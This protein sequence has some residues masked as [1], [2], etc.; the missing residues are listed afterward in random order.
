MNVVIETERLLLRRFTIDDAQ[1]V[2]ELNAD[3]EVTYYTHDPIDSVEQAKEVLERS[4]L[5][6]YA[7]YNHGRWAVHLKYDLAFIGWCGLKYRPALNEVDLGYRFKK[8]AWGKG[9]ATEAAWHC[10][11]YG[12]ERL[13]LRAITGRAE[14]E[15]KGSLRVLE[16]CGMLYRRQEQIDGSLVRTYE[17]INPSVR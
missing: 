1:L 11:R 15:N 7:L 10:I 8:D 5:P 9:Y 16:K 14:P 6:Q 2:Y 12:F 13:Y 3:S 17:I 4:I